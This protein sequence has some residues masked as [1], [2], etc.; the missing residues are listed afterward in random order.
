VKVI[1]TVLIGLLVFVGAVAQAD[2][3]TEQEVRQEIIDGNE[4]LR[5]NLKGQTDDYSKDGAI[6]FW[7]SGGMMH[8][9]SPDGRPGEF[10]EFNIDVF[11]IKVT[12]LVPG[13]VAMAHYYSQ[14]S[15]KPKNSAVVPN[16]F[17]RVSQVFVKEGRR[18][19]V[20]SSHWSAVKGGAGTSQTG[21]EE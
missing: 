13:K 19:K 10:D 4:Y 11:H 15:M 21:E 8:E 5:K 2:E 7:S 20:R 16:Y 12:T 18:W 3:K 14:G 17:T 1:A 9:V 6:E